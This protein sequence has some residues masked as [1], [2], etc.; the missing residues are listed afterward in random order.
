MPTSAMC[1]VEK[2]GS[3]F[4]LRLTGDNEHRLS[5][6][7]IDS[8]R[9]ALSQVKSEAVSSAGISALVT[10][11]DGK[12][13]S[14]GFDLAWAQS[15]G[16]RSGM[17]D[18]IHYMVESLKPLLADLLSLPMPTIA[19]VTG[20][21][22]AAGFMLALGHDYVLMRRDKGVLYMSELNIGMTLPEYFTTMFRE[23]VASPAARRDLLL[24]AEKIKAEEA[25]KFGI[26]D[27]V[28]DGEEA[29]VEAAIRLGKQLA[30]RKWNG[31]VY[32][33]IRKS[34]YPEMCK[35]LGLVSRTIVASRL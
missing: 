4:V 24:R 2:R 10:I 26:V 8:L 13:F 11:A 7:L 31:E 23:K 29:T 30:E 12:F 25:V 6:A 20:H 28:H 27:S 32:A 22:A 3:I 19:A 34:L 35:Q 33:E 17:V 18:R 16:S 1:T 15:S 9:S 5:P 14:N 21:A